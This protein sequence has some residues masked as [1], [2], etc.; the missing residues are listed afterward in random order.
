M[1]GE[2]IEASQNQLP[3][4]DI[5]RTSATNGEKII[6]SKE[7]MHN[8]GV[9]RKGFLGIDNQGRCNIGGIC[10]QAF[11]ELKN[12]CG[13]P[14][15]W[16]KE[17]MKRQDIKDLVLAYRTFG[18]L[19]E[20]KP[21]IPEE[22]TLLERLFNQQQQINT[23]KDSAIK[24]KVVL[25]STQDNYNQTIAVAK[26]QAELN[27]I[28]DSLD[29]GILLEQQRYARSSTGDELKGVVAKW[30][31]PGDMSPQ[32]TASIVDLY[33]YSL[34]MTDKDRASMKF[35]DEPIT[36]PLS[37]EEQNIFLHKLSEELKKAKA[38]L[39]KQKEEDIKARLARL[40]FIP[41]SYKL[42]L[43]FPRNKTT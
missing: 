8:Y 12:R 7:K 13:N 34:K 32:L 14:A 18:I 1:V 42:K 23:S 26:N 20:N 38:L 37:P 19:R 10:K 29:Q 15:N 43:I 39:N 40:A 6:S 17:D 31:E 35:L 5:H 9:V 41:A 33:D 4:A 28:R 21:L 3:K 16:S 2:V 27:A 22:A 36:R 24:N 30:G 11:E 25:L